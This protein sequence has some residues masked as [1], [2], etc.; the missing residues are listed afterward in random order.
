MTGLMTG[1]VNESIFV[2][3]VQCRYRHDVNMLGKSDLPSN[4]D[5]SHPT[6]P[7]PISDHAN[8]LKQNE[9]LA[10]TCGLVRLVKLTSMNR[11]NK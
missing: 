10:P 3:T 7:A 4:P 8:L 11:V 1:S 5:Y 2:N 6:V 9:R